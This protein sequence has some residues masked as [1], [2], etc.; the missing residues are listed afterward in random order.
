MYNM[1]AG[2]NA[3]K[4]FNPAPDIYPDADLQDDSSRMFSN[5]QPPKDF[6]SKAWVAA[7]QMSQQ[8]AAADAADA[9]MAR[10]NALQEN[11]IR[12]RA[13]LPGVEVPAI[14]SQTG[15]PLQVAA[16]DPTIGISDSRFP[17]SD[18]GPAQMPGG[19]DPYGTEQAINSQI[20]AIGEQKA[21]AQGVAKALGNLGT[22]QAGV[23][24]GYQTQ[25]QKNMDVYN[26]AN[27][28]LTAERQGIT[29]DIQDQHINP[30]QYIQNMSTGGRIL[31]GI[32]LILGGM[33]SG[34]TGGPNL[35]FQK[36]QM[37]IDRDIQSQRDDLGKKQNLL[38]N[39]LAQ[40]QNLRAASELT[41]LQTN[42]IVSSH[43]KQL[44][45]QA[46]DPIQKAN[47]QSISGLYDGQSA[48]LQHQLAIQKVMM[49][50]M[51]AGDPE[52][53]F[54]A[55]TQYLRMNG[56]EA[57]AKDM[58]A[59]H[60][61]GVGQADREV[62]QKD[63]SEM[64]SRQDLANKIADLQQFAAKNSGSFDPAIVNQG[65]AKA[66][67]VQDAYRRANAQGVFREAEKDFVSSIASPNPTQL[68][69][70]Y[71]AGQ[72][73]QEMGRDNLGTLNNLRQSYGLPAAFM[74]Q[75][76]QGPA[77]KMVNGKLYIRGK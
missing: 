8:K 17:S 38:S 36:M 6:D 43:L 33:G 70:K 13:G 24:Q 69:E 16:N 4:Q 35:A 40:T 41:R 45:Y 12:A 23:E 57:M 39:N 1:Q 9:A 66:A 73:Y 19:N 14:P 74:P 47:L 5:G 55:Q 30:Q 10:Q 21:G 56:N 53:A 20:A 28:D 3:A 59:K 68:F 31:Q 11:A 34:I 25:A 60:V 32:G 65:A 27:A 29:K 44:A 63:R 71:R 75:Q 49:N 58:E 22:Q 46:Q 62:D 52:A 42:D 61:A 7:E 51:G 54:K 37:D 26:Q 76:A 64:T 50:Q 18:Q 15:M 48:Q 2:V 67:L 72:G 77:T